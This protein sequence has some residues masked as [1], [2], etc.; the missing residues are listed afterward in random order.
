MMQIGLNVFWDKTDFHPHSRIMLTSDAR[1][2]FAVCHINAVNKSLD[3]VCTIAES[4]SNRFHALGLPYIANFEQANFDR[5]CKGPD[6]FEWANHADGTHRMVFPERMLKALNKNGNLLGIIYDEF[7]HMIIN[8]NAGIGIDAKL[9]VFP[10]PEKPSVLNDGEA[11]KQNLKPYVAQI[12]K[13]G[14]PRFAGEHVFPVLYHLFAA[15]GITPNFK[16]QKESFS[17]VQYAIAS[18]AALEYDTE[19]WNCVDMW[20]M[21]R[22]PG[23]S[24]REM[25]NNLVFA[26]ESGVS[27]VYVESSAA[28]VSDGTINEYG[29]EFIRFTHEYQGKPRSFGI[30][31]LRPKTAIIR[32]DDTYWGQSGILLWKR[33][34]FGDE[35]LKPKRRQKEYLHVFHLLTHGETCKNGINW[36]R[37]TLWSLRK[38]RSFATMGAL[39]VF[40]ENVR[41]PKLESLELCFLCGEYISE[42]TLKDIGLLVKNNGLVAVT[43]R[44]FL[45]SHVQSRSRRSTD[46]I[47]DGK[48]KWI[49]VKSF[50]SARL[51]RLLSGYLGNKGEIQLRFSDHGRKLR[52]SQDGDAL[53]V[54]DNPEKEVDM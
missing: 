21:R 40:D 50:K 22:H 29:R 46:V 15:S 1:L 30:S 8:R 37:F 26:Y 28:M 23:H 24:A 42:A 3:T 36:G 5:S 41:S 52:I 12:K 25:Y 4:I 2:D 6:G 7:E 18:G 49:V 53:T 54:A 33:I 34:L 9:N 16:S 47:P 32:Y 38:H 51:K 43:T 44:R 11:L 14:V 10:L 17:N 20:F 48:G 39:C 19:L 31:D 45:P 35:R 13:C 27:K